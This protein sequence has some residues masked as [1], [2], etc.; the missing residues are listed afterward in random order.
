MK[1]KISKA[2]EQWIMNGGEVYSSQAIAISD[3][4]LPKI[5]RVTRTTAT[6]LYLTEITDQ[7]CTISHSTKLDGVPVQIVNVD[8]ESLQ[9]PIVQVGSGQSNWIPAPKLCDCLRPIRKGSDVYT[10]RP[11]CNFSVEVFVPFNI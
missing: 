1:M 5:W 3:R 8:L 6:R 2:G 9:V 10:P 7:V 11:L 4:F